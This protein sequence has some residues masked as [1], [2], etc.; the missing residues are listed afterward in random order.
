MN[1]PERPVH[2][3]GMK[4]GLRIGIDFD[5][6]FC[7]GKQALREQVR[8]LPDGEIA[9]QRL[10]GYVYGK[11]IGG[12]EFV[13]GV[14]RFLRRCRAAGCFVT[15]VSHKTEFGHF[16][17]DRV[18][19][20]E[21]ARNWMMAQGLFTAEYGIAPENVY[22]EGT[23]SE[24]LARIERLGL[25][26]FIDDLEEVLTDPAFPASV[27]RIL[28]ANTRQSAADGCVMCSNWQEIEE[29]IFEHAG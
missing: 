28:F 15:V 5:N 2:G 6:T 23:R 4:P 20:R 12:A 10:Q 18:N 1:K 21:T 22:F 7:G 25:S 11:G 27:R 17:P 14:E 19:L 9:W 29:L 8:R 26:Y 13:P 24:K 3:F 16:D